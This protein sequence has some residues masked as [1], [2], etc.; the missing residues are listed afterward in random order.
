MVDAA[1]VVGTVLATVFSAFAV[2]NA[3][4]LPKHARGPVI[5]HDLVVIAFGI[6][7]ARRKWSSASSLALFGML[8]ALLVA[9]NI[10]LASYLLREP[11][12]TFY[13]AL[14]IV[15]VGA[16][17]LSRVWA[18]ATIGAIGAAWSAVALPMLSTRPFVHYG[19]TVLAAT[20]IGL[21][22]ND[23]RGRSHLRLEQLRVR[24][25]ARQKELEHSLRLVEQERRNLDRTVD[26]RTAA[27]RDELE[28]R[29]RL[30]EQLRQAQKTE[31]VGRLAGGIAHDFN[32][33]LTIIFGSL[34]LARE[35]S[36]KDVAV[37]E[38][39]D[40]ARKAAE[41]AAD[42]TRQLL[43]FGRRQRLERAPVR[44]PEI[45]TDLERVLGRFIGEQIELRREIDSRSTV[46]VDR[47]QIEQVLVNLVIN[48]RDAM[49]DGGVLT[50]AVRDED[51]DAERAERLGRP[52]GRWVVFEVDDSG[53][54][55]DEKTQ[56]SLFEPFFTTKAPGKGTGLGLA[57]A[58]GIVTQHHGVIDV[59]STVGR[60]SSF[61]VWLPATEDSPNGH[62]VESPSMPHLGRGETVLVVEDEPVLLRVAVRSLERHGYRV[63]GATS[64]EQA[65]ALAATEPVDLLVTD[66]IMPGI[67]G[68][69]LATRLRA[70]WPGLPVLFVSGYSADKLEPTKSLGGT[71]F[72]AK[73]YRADDLAGAVVDTLQAA[74]RGPE[75]AEV[76]NLVTR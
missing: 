19:F 59:R 18:L 34:D 3:V 27:L 73:P 1:P 36:G 5:A 8:T 60:G 38:A 2:F 22:I 37:L 74:A 42:L 17:L 62:R 23:A 57:T 25:A 21:L 58:H 61:S 71:R 35:A 48:A 72:L 44:A 41:R 4:D 46:T 52:A 47:G 55:M 11:F 63:L 64:G 31:A 45:I 33:L 68:P 28:E 7:I 51:V 40:D 75:R 15:A 43:A 16:T 67:D 66:V 49:P 69:Q 9:S 6:W 39:I 65:L 20:A 13:I 54:G 14:L 53:S 30:E 12:Y 32:N 29:R 76:R 56:A 50:I 70:R 24:D 26:E 10:L